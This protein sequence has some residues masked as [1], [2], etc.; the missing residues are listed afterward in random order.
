MQRLDPG[1]FPGNPAIV[2]ELHNRVLGGVDKLELQ[3]Q[4][5]ADTR[6]RGQVHNAESQPVPPGYEDAIAD[7]FRRLSKTP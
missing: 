6:Q 1:R 2:E 5:T 7:Y 4:R 3:L